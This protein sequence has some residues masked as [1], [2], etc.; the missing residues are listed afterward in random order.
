ME[1]SER[2]KTKQYVTNNQTSPTES[3]HMKTIHGDLLGQSSGYDG[4]VKTETTTTAADL[5]TNINKILA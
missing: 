1:D 5:F 4:V 2:H 3:R